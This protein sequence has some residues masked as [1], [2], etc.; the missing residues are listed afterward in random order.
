M[1][2]LL[3][4]K[5]INSTNAKAEQIGSA[6]TA[7]IA[8]EQ[9]NGK[10]RFDR[11]W[12]S[13]KG[14]IYLSLLLDGVKAEDLPFLTFIAA[15]SARKAIKLTT[16]LDTIIKWPNDLIFDKKK[17]CGILT[18]TILGRKKMA[19]IGIGI[20]T[21]NNLNPRLKN[22][23]IS[24]NKILGKQ[25]D[26]KKIIT[27]FLKVFEEY[28]KILKKKRYSKIIS[29]WKKHSFLGCKIKVKTLDKTYHGTAFD[30]DCNCLLLIKDKNNKNIKIHEGDVTII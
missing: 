30:I 5:K 10:G 7:I 1:F 18:K 17:L 21:N 28:Y 12:Y 27:T 19:V 26:N 23:A 8:E 14:G 3:Y 15:I 11:G 13:P 24:L 2:K 29:D 4:F 20:N 16:N 22:K 9:T 6:N 25:A